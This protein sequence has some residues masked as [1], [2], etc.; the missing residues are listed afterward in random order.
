[1]K[2]RV[3][4][5]ILSSSMKVSVCKT[6]PQG[7]LVEGPADEVCAGVGAGAVTGG[8]G[9]GT[10]AGCRVGLVAGGAVEVW[11]AGWEWEGGR[12]VVVSAVRKA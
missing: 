3:C 2:A 4:Q 9:D 6:V 5:R 11:D 7:A 10:P 8:G 1:M 12:C